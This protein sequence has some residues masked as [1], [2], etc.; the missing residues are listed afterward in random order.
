[1]TE[2]QGPFLPDPPSGEKLG[3]APFEK[4]SETE[5]RIR[6][7]AEGKVDRIERAIN[8]AQRMLVLK[9]APGFQPFQKAVEDLLTA[10]SQEMVGCVAGNEQ[11]RILQGRCQAF[12]SILALMRD[13]EHNVQ[14]LELSLEM[15]RKEAAAT[16]PQPVG[17]L[18]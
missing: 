3:A 16:Q 18:T 12:S 2:I 15:A 1:M 17:G 6:E 13:T 4:V 7:E 14:S 11:L 9:N 5:K 8:L 10:S